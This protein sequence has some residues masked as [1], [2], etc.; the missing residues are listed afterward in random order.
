MQLKFGVKL[1]IMLAPILGELL[2]YEQL[3][4]NGGQHNLKFDSKF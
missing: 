3:S 4:Q 1:Q 2:I